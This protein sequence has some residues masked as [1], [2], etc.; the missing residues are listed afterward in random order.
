MTHGVRALLG[1]DDRGPVVRINPQGRSS[2]L[3]IG[4]HAGRAIPKRLGTLG[5]TD[6][7]RA[8]H[9]AWDIGVAGLGE[10]MA[11]RMDAVFLHQHYSRLVIDCNRTPSSAEAMPARSDGTVIPGN[12]GI[13]AEERVSRIGKIHRP[14]HAAIAQEID[15]RQ[16]MGLA[17]IVVSLHSFTPMLDG[18]SRPWEI[19]VLHNRGRDDFAKAL[20][21]ELC[22]EGGVVVGDNMPYRMDATDYTVPLHAFRRD[23]PYAEIE[24]R[25]DLIA[26]PAGQKR[27]CAT[28][29]NALPAA[30]HG[31]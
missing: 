7:D 25:Q 28:L 11:G 1:P 27:W 13:P 15:R 19:G 12:H 24:I 22:A 18:I 2:F 3:L 5:L 16:A 26:S 20:L 29:A 23:L 4:D 21:A 9:I 6:I 14:Y 31:A 17:T 30:L 8:R 10:R